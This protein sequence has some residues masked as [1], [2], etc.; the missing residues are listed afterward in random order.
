MKKV[1]PS[2]WI[3]PSER[4]DVPPSGGAIAGDGCEYGDINGDCPLEGFLCVEG[5]FHDPVVGEG[6]EETWIFAGAISKGGLGKGNG[7]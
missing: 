7:E 5:L 2:A 6:E 4:G 1:G 3:E